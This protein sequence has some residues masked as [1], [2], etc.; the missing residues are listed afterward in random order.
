ML[1]NGSGRNVQSLLRMFHRCF[2]PSFGSFG[3]AISEKKI[4][5]NRPIRKKNCLWCPCLLTD[6]DE[7]SNPYRGPP[8]DAF[9]QDL[10][11]RFQRRIVF[12]IDQS[13]SRIALWGHVYQRIGKEWAIFIQDLTW[14]L[15]TKI[16]FIWPRVCRGEDC[17]EIHQSETVIA[18]RT[19]F[20]NGLE[21]NVQS[22]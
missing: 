22:L 7:M 17:F 1:I 18:C 9:Y 3:L 11:K 16:Q 6:R 19:M 21:R 13:K 5:Q 8:I 14:M 2:L 10:A 4:F 12:K 15:P 20:I